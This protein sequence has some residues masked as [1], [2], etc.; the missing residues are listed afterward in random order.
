MCRYG[1]DLE[2]DWELIEP[3]EW[4]W[5]PS[6]RYDHS[7]VVYEVSIVCMCLYFIGLSV[8]VYLQIKINLV[9]T[10]YP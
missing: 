5:W 8:C 6:A 7:A 3:Q 9:Y 10:N 2:E 4:E 1:L